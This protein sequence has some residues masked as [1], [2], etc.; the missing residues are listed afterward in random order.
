MRMSR[1]ASDKSASAGRKHKSAKHALEK[2]QSQLRTERARGHDRPLRG[3][4]SSHQDSSGDERS[5]GTGPPH[6]LLPMQQFLGNQAVLRRLESGLDPASI[7]TSSQIQPLAP[8]IGK[9]GVAT[10]IQTKLEVNTPGDQYEQEADRVAEEVVRIGP[11]LS[12]SP[13]ISTATR[14]IQHKC[15][16]GGTCAECEEK[17]STRIPLQMKSLGVHAAAG[18]AAP[19]VHSVLQSPG[20]PLDA[21][22]RAFMEP[23]FGQDFSGVRVHAGSQAADSAR[24]IHARAYTVGRDVVFGSN[25]FSPSTAEG[26]KLLAHELAHVVQTLDFASPQHI[27]AGHV[28]PVL[29]QVESGSES[30]LEAH[31]RRALSSF[32][33]LASYPPIVIDDDAPLLI[34]WAAKQEIAFGAPDTT[35]EKRR[36]LAEGLLR[37]L[38]ELKD[39]E[40]RVK[41]DPDGALVYRDPFREPVPWTEDRPKKLD[42]IWPFTKANIAEWSNAATS[43]ATPSKRAK[44]VGTVK[45][46][47]LDRPS[48]ESVEPHGSALNI[49]FHKQPGMTFKTEEGQR[50][51]MYY[52]IGSTRNFTADQLDWV[53]SKL[54]LEKRWAP[55]A[56]MDLATWQDTFEAIPSGGE[57]TMTI[58][59]KFGSELDTLVNQMPRTRDFQLE[60]VRQGVLDARF[61]VALGIGTFAVGTIAFGG[62]ALL[63]SALG[64]GGSSV[65]LASGGLL[66]EEGG[67]L[68]GGTAGRA[69]LYAGR[70]LYL[71]PMKFFGIGMMGWGGVQLVQ[72]SRQVLSQGA[73][74]SDIGQFAEE[75]SVVMGGYLDYQSSRPS[76]VGAS[77][78]EAPAESG[79]PGLVPARV[80]ASGGGASGGGAAPEVGEPD[81][82]IIRPPQVDQQTGR[83]VA[84]MTQ[85]STGRR[86]DVDID[87]SGNGQIVDRTSRQVV[88]VVRDGKFGPPAAG[89]LPSTPSAAAAASP[90]T[91][92]GPQEAGIPGGSSLP[93]ATQPQSGE[94]A[95]AEFDIR[96]LNTGAG[97]PVPTTART[98]VRQAPEQLKL[99]DTQ[100]AI[101]LDLAARGEKLNARQQL[102]VDSV[103]RANIKVPHNVRFELEEKGGT[104]DPFDIAGPVDPKTRAVREAILGDLQKAGVGKEGGTKD[105]LIVRQA[106]LTETSS[107][108]P[109][110]FFTSDDG[111]INGLARLGKI[112]P[113][114]GWGAYRNAAEFLHYEMGTET[115][116]LVVQGR[117]LIVKPIQPIRPNLPAPLA[118]QPPVRAATTPPT[119]IGPAGQITGDTPMSESRPG[120]PPAAAPKS[121][122]KS[123][124]QSAASDANVINLDQARQKR[125]AALL[126]SKKVLHLGKIAAGAENEPAVA[127]FSDDEIEESYKE[128][129]AYR[130]QADQFS[131]RDIAAENVRKQK[132]I[133]TSEYDPRE[134]D[135]ELLGERLVKAGMPK[136]GAGYQAHHIVPSNEPSAARLREFLYVRGFKDI[137]H[138]DNGVWLPTGSQTENLGSEF[139]HEF[140][141]DNRAF[142]G[143]YFTRLEEIL[144]RNRSISE[145]GIRLRLRAIRMYLKDGKLPPPNM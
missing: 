23:R 10:R 119:V 102:I 22:T 145:A 45:T 137:N 39:F 11:S 6:P 52:M 1:Q 60:G 118:P 139:K 71:N 136:P 54:G 128:K 55:P 62:G 82:L 50:T 129:T 56:G 48:P 89:L 40:T 144:M 142:N 126:A 110:I 99:A 3:G 2:P 67:S 124:P 30:D 61:G 38:N 141:F 65:A 90:T 18:I 106:L 95:E 79:E 122:T 133:R 132:T 5:R 109:P 25:Q 73:H 26:K 28:L 13:S 105:Q 29:R 138:P 86:F 104:K 80:G 7:E 17:Q 134:G 96:G 117:A 98:P 12:R 27:A 35:D 32:D 8:I 85:I 20:R 97:V 49:T 101:S 107:G 93:P 59:E 58:D 143:E 70:A 75:L 74:Y 63:G 87:A 140:T 120:T 78:G 112:F 36:Y 31:R 94:P 92:V 77:G 64:A 108:K 44:H 103:S 130:G 84:S 43:P 9:Q 121:V 91:D 34:R 69:A 123:D 14:G 81:F 131:P 19:A 24:Q 116:E 33:W 76:G 125:E 15:D 72:H 113:E 21:A 83:R 46:R 37:V 115:F 57:I 16:C 41:R 135:S 100:V 51:I 88:G 53:V 4:D 66:A 47:H 68:V 114:K 111:I 127:V 42:D